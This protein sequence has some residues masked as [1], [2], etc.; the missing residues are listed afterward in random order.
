MAWDFIVA[1]RAAV[2]A[3]LD[4]LQRLEYAGEIATASSDPAIADAL[5]DYARNFPEG[6][7]RSVASAAATIRLRAQTIAQRMPAVEA[8]VAARNAPP[9]RARR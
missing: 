1:H 8:W 5:V 3:M 6:A 4:P 9:Q 2:E 7:Q